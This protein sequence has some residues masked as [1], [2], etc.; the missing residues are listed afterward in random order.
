MSTAQPCLRNI[1]RSPTTHRGCSSLVTLSRSLGWSWWPS[2]CRYLP[3]QRVLYDSM[4]MVVTGNKFSV[5]LE[6]I[7]KSQASPLTTYFINYL[8]REFPHQTTHT[9]PPI[10]CS[11]ILNIPMKRTRGIPVP[12]SDPSANTKNVHH[13]ATLTKCW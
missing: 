13:P 6:Y 5:K 8:P 10:Q 12:V 2:G 1:Y 11:A 7:Y 4:W 3:R 9:H